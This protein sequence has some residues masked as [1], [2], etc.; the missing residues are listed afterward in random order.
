M[1]APLLTILAFASLAA[2]AKDKTYTVEFDAMVG[3]QPFS[4][5]QSYAGIGTSKTTI[6]PLDFR[7]YVS[8]VELVRANG[9]AVPLALIPD[10]VWQD[11]EVAYLDFEDATG[12]CTN[13]TPQVNTQ[14]V[15]H[16]PDADYTAIRF[17]LGVPA[18]E[19]HLNIAT[20]KAPLDDSLMYWA[21]AA[22]YRY[23]KLEVQSTAQPDFFFHLGAMDCTGPNT[24][25]DCTYP[26]VATVPL[27]GFAMGTSHV[28]VDLAG[29]YATS[30]LDAAP[31]ADDTAGCHSSDG[32]AACEPLF[33]A[34][35]LTF[36]S[37]SPG[38]P[39]TFFGVK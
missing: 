26:N 28:S 12:T 25:V 11:D 36:M 29:L 22:G 5:T 15:G 34:L 4:C 23:M 6:E 37:N 18:D 38:P 17:A 3:G 33:N 31:P 21:W 7:M 14:I 8:S 35:G 30:N 9:D 1:R 20:A 32:E 2:C 19:D 16:A 39:Q 24:S 27:T 13:G 10:G